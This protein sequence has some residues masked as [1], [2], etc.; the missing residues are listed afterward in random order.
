MSNPVL[1]EERWND[2][3]MGARA[4]A[5]MTVEGAMN[6]TALLLVVL[7][8][9]IGGMWWRFWYHGTV[10]AS[11]VTPYIIGG[12]IA[13]L[14]MVVINLFAPRIAMAT[15][16][17]YA[18]AEGLVLG[19]LTMLVETR[20]HGLPL[21]AAVFTLGTLAG[22]VFLVR[23]G[24]IRASAGFIR[25]V[26]IATAG[27]VLGLGVLALLRWFEVGF[28]SSVLAQLHGNGAIGLGFSAVCILLATANLVSDLA[29]IELGAR[30]GAPKHYEW[31]GAF[32]LLVTLVWLYVE[33]LRLL[34]KLR[35]RD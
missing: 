30:Q 2:A 9:T 15:S 25:G 10:V 17:V 27:L 14:V 8:A 29:L 3:A 23:T 31:V 7:L 6:R 1:N 16:L 11:E 33:I 12:V 20:F 34:A 21:L 19:G 4:G 26:W 13:G 5:V 22:C 24:I 28:A 18:V 35:S 32:G